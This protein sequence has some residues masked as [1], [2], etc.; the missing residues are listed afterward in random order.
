MVTQRRRFSSQE[1]QREIASELAND[2]D[3]STRNVIRNLRGRGIRGATDTLRAL[4]RIQRGTQRGQIPGIGDV[5]I[6][7]AATPRQARIILRAL[8]AEGQTE[9]ATHVAVRY[10][11]TVDASILFYGQLLHRRTYKASG[12]VVQ[13]I[14]AYNPELIAERIANNIRGQ[15]SVDIGNGTEG[16]TDG[17]EVI[18]NR[19]DVSVTTSELRG[20]AR[21]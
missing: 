16:G 10:E 15:V 11:G 20:S 13:P 18:I 2:P 17:I 9:Q 6:S 19:S 12:T 8:G 1:L 5:D 14:D 7:V 4:T 3:I 21:R